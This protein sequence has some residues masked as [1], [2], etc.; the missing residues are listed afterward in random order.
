M[1]SRPPIDPTMHRL[2]S[3]THISAGSQRRVVGKFLR[4]SCPRCVHRQPSDFPL[5]KGLVSQKQ[6]LFRASS[7]FTLPKHAQRKR[8]FAGSQRRVVGKFLRS[9]S[10]RCVH[11]QPSDSPL[12]KG[13]VS[14]K[15][16]LF[17]ASSL[18]TPPKHAQRKR[19]FAGSQR[20]VV[21]KFLRSSSPR[22]RAP[23]TE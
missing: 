2:E 11:R 22:M 23:S 21:G 1:I 10:P 6:V 4:S 14:Q 3:A 7:L 19:F 18:F 12:F 16:V 20:R 17:R 5:F 13:L 15:Q 9:S 8:F